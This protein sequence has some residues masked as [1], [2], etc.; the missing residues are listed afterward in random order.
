MQLEVIGWKKRKLNYLLEKAS[1]QSRISF[2]TQ[3]VS[4]SHLMFYKTKSTKRGE[5]G[6]I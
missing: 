6:V 4:E 5:K 2:D 1:E 3:E